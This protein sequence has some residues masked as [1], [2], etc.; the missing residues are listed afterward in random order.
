[1]YKFSF[2]LGVKAGRSIHLRTKRHCHSDFV[3][4]SHAKQALLPA[5]A[6]YLQ[7]Q[8]SVA[9]VDCWSVG[10]NYVHVYSK[11]G[12]L[13]YHTNEQNVSSPVNYIFHN[14]VSP[15][16]AKR[17]FILCNPNVQTLCINLESANAPIPHIEKTRS[18]STGIFTSKHL[19]EMFDHAFQGNASLQKVRLI[20][21]LKNDL[22][23]W[24]RGRYNM[25]MN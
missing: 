25:Q 9:C 21:Q 6:Q 20:Y 10:L 11:I 4:C 14:F 15:G 13:G 8:K 3:P 7:T 5:L 17:L 24:P 19:F 1:M 18:G 2:G 23:T 12:I 22:A 16:V